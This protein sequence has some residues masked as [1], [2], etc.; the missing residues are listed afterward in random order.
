MNERIKKV[1]LREKLSQ[2]EFGEALGVSRDVYANIENNRVEPKDTFIKLLCATYHINED[3][4]RTGRGDMAV[5]LSKDDEFLNLIAEIQVSGDEFVM[6][7]LR[8]Y[9]N[10][11]DDSKTIIRKMINDIADK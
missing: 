5:T 6:R 8:A 3:W 11:D 1:R 10:L 4:L 9:W 7:L 2:K